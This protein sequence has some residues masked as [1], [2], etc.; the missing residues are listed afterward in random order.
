VLAGVLS[1]EAGRT[2][3]NEFVRTRGHY[4]Q[5]HARRL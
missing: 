5:R 2:E 3:D 1:S 4:W